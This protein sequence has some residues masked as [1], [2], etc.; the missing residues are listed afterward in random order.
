MVLLA[1]SW[2][3]KMLCLAMVAGAY[4]VAAVQQHTAYPVAV[5]EQGNLAELQLAEQW[6]LPQ[7]QRTLCL[8]QWPPH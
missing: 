6:S 3:L 8:P 5:H 2:Q 4:E 7:A 1:T